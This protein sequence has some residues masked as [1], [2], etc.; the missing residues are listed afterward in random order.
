MWDHTV[1]C[2]GKNWRG[3]ERGVFEVTIPY[4]STANTITIVENRT[5]YV[6]IQVACHGLS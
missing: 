1:Q 4:M 6:K 3:I 2:S 5:V